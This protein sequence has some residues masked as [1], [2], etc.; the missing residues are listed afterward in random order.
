M[1]P[2]TFTDYVGGFAAGW[3]AAGRSFNDQA[4]PAAAANAWTRSQETTLPSEVVEDIR[5]ALGVA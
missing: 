4:F 2:T 1:K 5:E 3:L